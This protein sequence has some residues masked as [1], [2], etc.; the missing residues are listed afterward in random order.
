MDR[1]AQ[2]HEV[3]IYTLKNHTVT[4]G[5]SRFKFPLATPLAHCQGL[6]IGGGAR[7]VYLLR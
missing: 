3:G 7:T 4:T 6:A 2:A 5:H 1:A